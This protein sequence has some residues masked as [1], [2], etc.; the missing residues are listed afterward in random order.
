MARI[1]VSQEQLDSWVMEE[2]ARLDDKHLHWDGH[3]FLIEAAVR[4]IKTVG[5]EADPHGLLGRVKTLPQLAELSAE[6]YMDSVLLGDT[7]YEV[8][9][10]FVGSPEG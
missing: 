5:G 3:V 4:F 10:G 7:G 6:H 9:Q 2:T 1:F 8:Q